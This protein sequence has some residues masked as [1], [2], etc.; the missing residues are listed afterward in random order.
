MG[1]RVQV[2]VLEDILE[3]DPIGQ[4]QQDVDDVWLL[5]E[6]SGGFC[7]EQKCR[8]GSIVEVVEFLLEF[9]SEEGAPLLRVSAS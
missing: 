3:H 1:C 9:S 8:A 2:V 7:A 4:Q 6:D 5:L